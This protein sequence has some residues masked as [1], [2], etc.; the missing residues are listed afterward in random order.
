MRGHATGNENHLFLQTSEVLYSVARLDKITKERTTMNNADIH[1]KTGK[2]NDDLKSLA[3]RISEALHQGKFTAAELQ[4]VLT[5]RAKKAARKTD[6]LVH[7]FAWTAV[8]MGVGVGFLMGLLAARAT[9]P[10]SD[11]EPE[12]RPKRRAPERDNGV[13]EATSSNSTIWDKFQ[14]ILPLTVLA[15]KTYQELRGA[16]RSL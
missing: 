7:D 16:K 3:D 10:A 5:D 15:V 1:T 14:T 2:A 8:G 6:D 13:N 11:F 4:A 12:P 9:Q